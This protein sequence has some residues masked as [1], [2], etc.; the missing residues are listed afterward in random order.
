MSFQ[1]IQAI[2][3]PWTGTETC[4]YDNSECT[5]SSQTKSCRVN[6]PMSSEAISNTSV[7]KHWHSAVEFSTKVLFAPRMGV[8]SVAVMTCATR[9]G[10]RN[11]L[12]EE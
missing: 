10:M 8:L 9:S 7:L 12:D 3:Q 5:T 2:G 4:Q 6:H 1:D 11:I